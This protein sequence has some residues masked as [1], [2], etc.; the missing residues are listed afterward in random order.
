M[1]AHS[2]NRRQFL[3]TFGAS[4]IS[5]LALSQCTSTRS[6]STASVP[7]PEFYQSNDG[8]LSISLNADYSQVDLAG[9]TARLF[10]YNG[11]VPG[12]RLEVQPGD[13]IRIQFANNLPDPTNLHYHGLHVSP[14]GNADN[15]FLEIPPGEAFT[16]EFT[17]PPD[18]P[19]GTFWYHPHRHGL[20]AEQLFGGLTG[21]LI[22]RGQLDQI[23]EIQAAKEAFLVLKD[24]A[25]Q[26]NGRIQ[27]PTRMEQMMQ[28]REGELITINGQVNPNFSIPTGGLF[29]LRL[30]NASSSRFYR[31]ALEDHP[32]YLIATDGGALSEP[33]ELRELLLAPGERAEVL[34]R[35]EQQSGKYRLL[36][37]PYDRGSMGMMGRGG[38]MGRQEGFRSES[39]QTLATLTYQGQVEPLPLP[40]KIIPIAVLSEPQRVRRFTLNHSMSP[41]QGMVFLING[42]AFDPQRIDTLVRLN[43]TEDWEIVN[44]GTMDHPFHLHTNLFQVIS[45][46]GNTELYQAWKDTVLVPAGEGVRIRIPFQDF[47]GKAVYHCHILDHEDSGMMG[48]VEMQTA[49]TP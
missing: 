42:K 2:F 21:L 41:G 47:P 44:T 31:L 39:P 32:F 20:V 24:F 27:P 46:N 11:R 38:M 19:A 10:N 6:R 34:V 14:G 9:R 29:R 48:V 17:I 15:V 40:E 5:T 28:G 4:A 8:L 16:Y 30:L 7:G 45:R 12:P 1:A 18:H 49:A 22:V 36:N 23:P 26:D 43:T 25:L 35:G 3:L 13:T 33:V 37:L